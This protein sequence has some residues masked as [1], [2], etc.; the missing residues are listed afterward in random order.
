VPTEDGLWAT[1]D[2]RATAGEN[3]EEVTG[4]AYAR[5]TEDGFGPLTAVDRPAVRSDHE[6]GG[7]RYVSR[8]ELADGRERLYYEYTRAD[9]AHELRTELVGA[10]TEPDSALLAA[11]V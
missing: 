3:W 9:G 1:Y 10:S 2:G 5:R 6:P 8:V 11:T 7:L 4:I